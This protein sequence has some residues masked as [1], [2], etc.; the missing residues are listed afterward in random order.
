M[1]K[2]AIAQNPFV[3]QGFQNLPLIHIIEEYHNTKTSLKRITNSSGTEEY[4]VEAQSRSFICND[5]TTGLKEILFESDTVSFRGKELLLF[6]MLYLK[7]NIDYIDLGT[8]VLIEK[9]KWKD[10]EKIITARKEL[11]SIGLIVLKAES[12][13]WINPYYLFCGNR[14]EYYKE[15]YPNNV[16]IVNTQ[17]KKL[18]NNVI[19]EQ[20]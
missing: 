19:E 2:S 15:Y 20:L 9:L 10:R 8:N 4:D 1:K 16:K 14:L 5:R 7:P 12:V 13:Y 6:I 3:I 17:R 11:M 18:T